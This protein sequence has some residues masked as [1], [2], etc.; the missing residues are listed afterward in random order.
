MNPEQRLGEYLRQRK[1]SPAEER[2]AL[3]RVLEKLQSEGDQDA[4]EFTQE[5]QKPPRVIARWPMWSGAAAAIVLAVAVSAVF[6]RTLTQYAPPA[7][8]EAIDGK[9]NIEFGESV[10]SNDATGLVVKLADGSRVEM[11]SESE[12][13]LER[14]DDGVRIRLHTGGVIVNAAKQRNGHLYVQTKD[15]IVSVVGTVFL[16]NADEDGSRVAVIEGEVHVQQGTTLKKLL[17]GDQ[18]ATNPLM[19][20]MPVIAE[21]AWSRNAAAHMA[22]LQQSLALVQPSTAV[23]PPPAPKRLEFDAA[24]VKLEPRPSAGDG[25]RSTAVFCHAV[26]GVVGPPGLKGPQDIPQGWCVGRHVNLVSLVAIA[27][28]MKTPNPRLRVAGGPDWVTDAWGSGYEIEAKAEDVANVTREQL[29]LMLQSLADDRFKLK[30]SRV[31]REVDG[32]ALL[33]A[34]GGLKIQEVTA[35]EPLARSNKIAQGRIEVGIKG[36]ATMKAF[37]ENLSFGF[38]TPDKRFVDMTGLTG[39]YAINL[40]YSFALPPPGEAGARGGGGDPG[41]L[42]ISELGAALQ[43]QLGLR[44]EYMKVPDEFIVIEHAEKPTEN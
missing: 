31:T 20:P 4:K 35:E 39:I 25:I 7:V 8:V 17:P 22:L 32:T 36:K 42:A 43:E 24:S 44:L 10:R 37:A 2:A 23:P 9:R 33:V 16:V 26:D 21:I 6:V 12:L 1:G 27:Y 14:A 30:V 41:A 3:D 29:R 34:K 38:P 40:F 28:D 18:V 15:V 13:S 19:V 11:R 5:F